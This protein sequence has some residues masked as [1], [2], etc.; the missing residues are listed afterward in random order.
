M[1]LVKIMKLIATSFSV[2]RGN[3]EILFEGDNIIVT[4]IETVV[5]YYDIDETTANELRSM[6][7]GNNVIKRAAQSNEIYRWIN[8]RVPYEFS[9]ADGRENILEAIREWEQLTCLFFF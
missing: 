8:R 7:S 2:G 1:C 6:Y 3:G 5:E 4:S 9:N